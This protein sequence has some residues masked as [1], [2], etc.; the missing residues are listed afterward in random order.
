[1][2]VCVGCRD[3]LEKLKEVIHVA[4]GSKIDAARPQV[5]AAEENLH[6]MIVD[7]DKVVGKVKATLSLLIIFLPPSL[8]LFF[9]FYL[10]FIRSFL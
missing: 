8:L 2:C 5:L 9:V 4:K 1:M 3:E 7:L 6:S 10:T